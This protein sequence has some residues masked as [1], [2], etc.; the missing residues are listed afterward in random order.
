MLCTVTVGSLPLANRPMNSG[1]IYCVIILCS[2]SHSIQSKG[3]MN[4]EQNPAYDM[5]ASTQIPGDTK[6]GVYEIPES[7]QPQPTN[8]EEGVYEG[9]Y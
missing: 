2:L 3:G 7:I 5:I 9:V 1:T 4:T 6:G 8:P